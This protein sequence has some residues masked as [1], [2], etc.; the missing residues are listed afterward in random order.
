MTFTKSSVLGRTD[1]SYRRFSDGKPLPTRSEYEV[2]QG[3]PR[4]ARPDPRFIEAM[5]PNILSLIN[6]LRQTPGEI[7]SG[8]RKGGSGP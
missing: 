5:R 7:Y 4:V 3:I 1:T 8:P 2:G 6:V